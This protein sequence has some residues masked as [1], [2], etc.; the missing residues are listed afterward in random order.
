MH[1]LGPGDLGGQIAHDSAVGRY[2]ASAGRLGNELGRVPHDLWRVAADDLRPEVAE[3]TQG[4]GVEGA[5]GRTVDA[6]QAQTLAHFTGGAGGERDGHDPPRLLDAEVDGVGD[7][8]RDGTGLAGAR[9]GPHDDWALDGL[10]HRPL[11][12]V[13]RVEVVTGHRG[14]VPSGADTGSGGAGAG[15]ALPR[16]RTGTTMTPCR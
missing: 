5:H 9:S 6:E 11:L 16:R 8:V 12:G 2:P 4:R 10:G 14:I 15:L 7:A 13:E 1:L 3:L